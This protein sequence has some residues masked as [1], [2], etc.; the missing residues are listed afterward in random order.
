M[1]VLF[2]WVIPE[3]VGQCVSTVLML[4]SMHWFI[5]LLNLPVAAWDV[6]RYDSGVDSIRPWRGMSLAFRF[7]VFFF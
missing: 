2:Q 1:C 4:I 7:W 5:C 3:I 6:Y